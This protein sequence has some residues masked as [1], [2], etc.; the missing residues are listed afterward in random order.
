MIADD[1]GGA[2]EFNSK[3][4][5]LGSII[6]FVLDD[7]VDVECRVNKASNTIGALRFIWG[8]LMCL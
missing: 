2:V 5:C 1:E 4:S 7:I 8:M 3:F 6:N